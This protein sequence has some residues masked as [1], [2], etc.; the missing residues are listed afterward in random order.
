MMK[1][2]TLLFILFIVGCA[3]KPKV[4]KKVEV[5]DIT[6]DDFKKEK[7]ERYDNAKDRFA[8]IDKKDTEALND[9]SIQRLEDPSDIEIK[10]IL[11]EIIVKCYDKEFDKAL[12]LIQANHD[13]YK[14]HPIFWNQVGTCF[15]LKGDRRK[16]LLF[17]NKALEYKSSY[18]PAYNNLGVMYRNENQ[19]PKS[20]VAYTRSKKTNS[21]SKTPRF[22]LAQLYLEYGLYNQA[23]S[24]LKGLY[25]FSKNDVEVQAGLGTAYLMKGDLDQAI[26]YFEKIDNDYFEKAHIGINYSLALYLK[27]NKEKAIDV[28]EDIEKEKLNNWKEYYFEVSKK[29]GANK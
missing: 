9:E 8:K 19:D 17:Y 3:S 10:T 29:I 25:N 22:N 27:G 4:K 15:M 7:E 24:M 13:K 23:I 11:D 28:F 1:I 18:A 2:A 21:T 5:D 12:A 16:A 20:L 14:Q 6:K 26:S